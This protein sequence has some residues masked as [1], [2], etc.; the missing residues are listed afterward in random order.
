MS[1]QIIISNLIN[2]NLMICLIVRLINIVGELIIFHYV[3]G[4][5]NDLFL[6]LDIK[7][8]SIIFYHD[9]DTNFFN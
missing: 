2:I 3:I 4:V 1:G 6:I 8:F 5:L 9:I 7:L